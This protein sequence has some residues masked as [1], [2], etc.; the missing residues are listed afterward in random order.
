[1]DPF[2]D[3]CI[4]YNLRIRGSLFINNVYMVKNQ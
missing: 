1:M 3:E 2:H 4:A